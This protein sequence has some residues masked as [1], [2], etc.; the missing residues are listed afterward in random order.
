MTT[1][2]WATSK[3]DRYV[4]QIELDGVLIKDIYLNLL[5]AAKR[6]NVP[7]DIIYKLLDYIHPPKNVSSVEYTKILKMKQNQIDQP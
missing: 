3:T 7:L 5:L 2:S 4:L 1:I 6:K